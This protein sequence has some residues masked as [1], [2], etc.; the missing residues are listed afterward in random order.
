MENQRGLFFFWNNLYTRNV[1]TIFCEKEEFIIW[2]WFEALWNIWD[3]CIFP[4]VYSIAY[5]YL[6][7]SDEEDSAQKGQATFFFFFFFSCN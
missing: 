6:S 7:C 3:C 4:V 1:K 2:I 5:F